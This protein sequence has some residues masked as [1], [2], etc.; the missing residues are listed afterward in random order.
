MV[1][2]VCGFLARTAEQRAQ[3]VHLSPVRDL[4]F[5][6]TKTKFNQA[7]LEE[8]F[9]DFQRECP[10]GVLTR[11][12]ERCICQSVKLK[13]KFNRFNQISFSRCFAG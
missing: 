8:W 12:K 10:N 6:L 1:G 4:A 7:E 3:A 9:A 2:R 5:L 11:E 13:I